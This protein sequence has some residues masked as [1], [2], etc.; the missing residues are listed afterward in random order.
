MENEKKTRR[1]LGHIEHW[2][3]ISALLMVYDFIAICLAYF[4]A[5]W[6]R[7]DGLVRSIP[8]LWYQP[9]IQFII[10]CAAV[11]IIIFL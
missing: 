1:W 7:F 10:P 6:L 9:Y 2:Q 4:L 3:I 5:L 8:Q 11:S